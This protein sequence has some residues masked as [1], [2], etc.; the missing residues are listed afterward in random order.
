MQRVGEVL[1]P[2]DAQVRAQ[3][4]LERDAADARAR[5]ASEVL[6]RDATEA[7]R[8][9]SRPGAGICHASQSS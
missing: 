9:G 4:A 6:E 1:E 2:I 7:G 5:E 8:P 3:D